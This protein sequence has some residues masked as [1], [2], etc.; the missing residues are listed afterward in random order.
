MKISIMEVQRGKVV[1]GSDGSQDGLEVAILNLRLVNE[2]LSH[3]KSRMALE[4]PF[5]F[6]TMNK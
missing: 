1:Q 4:D 2:Q 3:F 6:G 5:F